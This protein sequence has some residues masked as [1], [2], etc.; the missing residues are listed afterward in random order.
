MEGEKEGKREREN[1]Y[2]MPWL[3]LVVTNAPDK[4]TIASIGLD[5]SVG[6]FLDC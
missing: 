2:V 5:M 4:L 3:I 6:H 1:D